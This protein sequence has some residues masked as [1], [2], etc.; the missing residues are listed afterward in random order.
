MEEEINMKELEISYGINGIAGLDTNPFLEGGNA[1]LKSYEQSI[2]THQIVA[3]GQATQIAPMY[4]GETPPLAL[5]E[6]KIHYPS[7]LIEGYKIA[8]EQYDQQFMKLV[9]RYKIWETDYQY[10]PFTLA[11]QVDGPAYSDDFLERTQYMSPTVIAEFI[12]KRVF[13]FEANIAAY[14]LNGRLWPDGTTNQTWQATLE[15]VRHRTGKKVA[16]LAGSEQKL[17]EMMLY[18]MG[19]KRGQCISPEA[20]RSLTGFD[21]FLGPNDLVSVYQQYQGSDCPYVFFGR[22]SRPKSWLRNPSSNVDEG[23]LAYPEILR[24]VRAHAIT[25]NFDGPKLSLNHPSILM[26]SKEALVMVGAAYLVTQPSDIYSQEFLKYL[27][28]NGIDMSDIAE[29][30]LNRGEKNKLGEI[31]LKFPATNLLSESLN[32]HLQTRGIDPDLIASGEK[33]VRAKPLK[34]HYGIYGHEVGPVNR[35]RF[36]NE[37]V[38]Q[39]RV[40]GYYIIQPEFSNLHIVD[41]NNPQESYVAIDRV[42]FIRGADGQLYPMESCRSLMPAQSYEGKKN[43]VH[44]GSYTRCARIAI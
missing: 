21:A 23:F 31:F 34:Q 4:A 3:I 40:R 8:C 32:N 19:V 14:G 1:V 2:A 43:N 20:V 9:G 11:F 44:E 13:E 12:T 42:F 38:E 24:Y 41:S 35:A 16:I 17:N 15:N 7:S 5:R 25:H 30:I 37:L 39:I 26:D 28:D 18:E 36:L 29:G 22:T 27:S 10:A 6:Y 33:K